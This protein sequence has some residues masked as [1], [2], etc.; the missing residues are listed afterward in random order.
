MDTLEG[1]IWNLLGS[2]QVSTKRERIATLPTVQRRVGDGV[3]L[4]GSI[5]ATVP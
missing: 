1:D 5:P 2:N 3:A 4:C